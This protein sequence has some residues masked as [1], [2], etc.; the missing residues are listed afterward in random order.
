MIVIAHEYAAIH[1][2]QIVRHIVL[3][4]AV[5]RKPE[6]DIV[7]ARA[8]A[9]Q[10]FVRVVRTRSAPALRN[11]RTVIQHGRHVFIPRT[12]AEIRVAVQLDRKR[13]HAR[14]QREMQN[15]IAQLAVEIY[16]YFKF[17]AEIPFGA[18]YAA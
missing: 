18:K 17:V 11:R 8:L 4:L 7:N 15:I 3:R 14:I 5:A 1:A 10:I 16:G 13:C 12:L 9:N 2:A 6:V